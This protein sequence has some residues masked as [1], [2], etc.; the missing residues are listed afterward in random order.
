MK[1][2]FSQIDEAI[3]LADHASQQSSTWA[4]CALAI[5]LAIVLVAV[6]RMVVADKEKIGNRLTEVT[7]RHIQVCENL[8]K[9][10][11]ANTAVLHQVEKKL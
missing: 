11:E 8:S 1:P 2:F 5:V 7:D 4:L 6:W 3:K 9:V 10:V